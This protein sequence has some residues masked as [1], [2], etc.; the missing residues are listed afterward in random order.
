[1]QLTMRKKLT[2][3]SI[4]L[5]L[6]TV[7]LTTLASVYLGYQQIREQNQTRLLNAM[8]S[9]ERQ[10]VEII[11]KIN[12][13]IDEFSRQ[14]YL[15]QSLSDSA[16]TQSLFL[17]IQNFNF[18]EK[19]RNSFFALSPSSEIDHYAFYYAAKKGQLPQLGLQYNREL[20][21]L[22]V[23]KK[24]VL[25]IDPEIDSLNKD[26]V[27]N[28]LDEKEISPQQI[29]LFP[30]KNEFPPYAFQPFQEKISMVFNHALKENDKTIGYFVLEVPLTLDFTILDQELGVQTNLYDTSGKMLKGNLPFKDLPVSML[31]ESQQLITLEDTK[32]N[33]Y[34][35]LLMPIVYEGTPLA[36]L[37]VS[38]SQSK[39]V[40]Q[41]TQTVRL[42]SIIG[43][44]VALFG[45][46]LSLFV[47][48]S[49]T[50]PIRKVSA[51]LKDIAEGDGDLTKRL[52]ID[53]KDELGEMANWFNIFVLKIHE[54]VKQI[55][56]HA[57]SLA[58][59][60]HELSLN[61]EEMRLT[62]DNIAQAVNEEAEAL[63]ES[64]STISTIASSNKVF[65][66][67]I[68][69][70]QGMA[71]ETR[72]NAG[73]SFQNIERT[74]DT[75]VKIAGSSKKIEGVIQV[76]TE[77]ANQTNLLSLNAAIEA[78]KAGERGKGFAVVA[79][80]VRSLAERS[81]SSVIEIRELIDNSTANVVEGN[82]V[83]K[84]TSKTMTEIITS[85]KQITGNIH[86]VTENVTGQDHEIQKIAERIDS[87]SS[88]SEQNA[89]TSHELSSTLN[90]TSGTIGD[91]AQ[92]AEQLAKEAQQF[93]V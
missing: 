92:L 73:V 43:F 65:T 34:D 77:I 78:A 44:V 41:I 60:T 11:P 5:I 20:S 37:S 2:F 54:M 46:L 52:K 76:I 50:N 69:S 39:T 71:E 88:L 16:N 13:T 70:V 59:A 36:Y 84:L 1:M 64:A 49:F 8:D 82:E 38:I 26:K 24:T 10:M 30:E 12:Q 89:S 51:L 55:T 29:A 90:A 67:E 68:H 9:V 25:R 21:A 63:R 7:I 85:V 93:K 40:E 14:P 27:K 3:Y 83:I 56:N 17:L 91:L 80:E 23:D 72:Q 22:I 6:F 74:N 28:L 48:N 19:L 53:S 58:V 4:G 75:M 61:A 33:T 81:A 31:S 62:S 66:N 18:N 87:I 35:S 15:K 32:H 57:E 86:K 47:V 79:D 45:T 42:L